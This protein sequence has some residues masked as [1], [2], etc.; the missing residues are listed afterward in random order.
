TVTWTVTDLCETFELS[1][2]F[3]LAP[4][5]DVTY[6]EPEDA[7][8]DACDFADQD[9][10]DIA[11]TDWVNAQSAAIA[12]AGGCNPQL[13]NDSASVAIPQLCDGG[14]ATVTWI[15]TDT[16]ET[17]E[18]KANFN[19]TAPTS[20]AFE[21][22]SLPTDI[23]VECDS[24]P[25]AENLTASN[26]CGEVSVI[27]T[28]ER[29]DDGDCVSN[30]TLIRT[31]VA[32]D[33]CG[34]S[35]EHKQ[36]ITVQ[37]T[38]APVLILPANATAE[39]S[40]DLSPIS[41][42]TATATDNC[43]ANPVI[44]YVD[45]TTQG[46]CPGSI[47]IIRTWTATDACGNS[48]SE[49]QTISTS[50]T[51]PPV[52]VEELPEDITVECTAIPN[53]ETLTAT[54]NCGNANVIFNEVITNGSCANNYTISRTWT[55]VDECGLE[56]SHT[57][58]IT[59]QDTTPPVFVESLPTDLTVECDAIPVA[60]VLTATDNCGNASVTVTDVQIAGSCPNA[61][62][63]E[64][65]WTATDE[66][67]LS[68]THT[69]IIEV[70]DTKAPTFVES[71]PIDITVECDAIPVAQ[72]LTAVDNCGEAT[73]SVQDVKT[74]GDCPNSYT[75][76]RTWTAVDAC[77]LRTSHTQIITVEDTTA[78]NVITSFDEVLNVSCADIPEIPSLEFEDNC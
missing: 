35:I 69:Q 39:C 56:T 8:V 53:A 66:C 19:L 38:T 21:Q 33:T 26:S 44:T 31:W 29:I 78:P 76:A 4:A 58:L 25:N 59:V 28:E 49:N 7:N 34:T 11:F 77:G 20:V 23:T 40:A 73:V 67:G 9:A 54:D 47:S 15:I 52:F 10:V 24:V 74:N 32:T 13:T 18:V 43:D 6:N 45:V 1:A 17:I 16:C 41:F 27:F 22:A 3:N 30:Y 37:D 51:T 71:L 72:T 55:A 61:F 48:V 60:E 62:S 57:Q 14:S 70:Q 36:T 5:D 50:D 42:G 2:D 68:T 64:R 63:I 75:I 46:P 12:A 65:T